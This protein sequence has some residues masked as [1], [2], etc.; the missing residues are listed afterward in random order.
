[1]DN[2]GHG[3]DSNRAVRIGGNRAHFVTAFDIDVECITVKLK[4]VENDASLQETIV[5]FPSARMLNDWTDANEET[6][7]PLDIIGFDCYPQLERWKFVLNCGTKEWMWESNWP[8][9]EAPLGR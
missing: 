8:T 2:G 9:L 4:P 7:W 3:V 5:R 1:M 6:Q